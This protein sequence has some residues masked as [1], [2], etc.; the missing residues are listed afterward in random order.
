MFDDQILC[1]S[2]D[3][4]TEHIVIKAG[5]E[6]LVRCE[7]CG[8]VH[9]VQRE[10]ERFV[11]LKVIVSW[12]QHSKPHHIAMPKDEELQVGDE[13]LV[14]DP[15]QDVVMTEITS[16][17]AERRV[18]AAP[19]KDVRTVWARAIDEVPLKISV[20]RSGKTHA[21]KIL[22]P[23][24]EIIV[25]GDTKEAEGFRFRVVKIKLRGEGFADSAPARAITRVW[26]RVL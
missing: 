14:D 11:N 22:L 8:S 13:L 16:L 25:V 3:I 20:Y 7:E 26:G 5:Q 2:C 9:S 15:S 4:E 1:P 19:A 12:D 17:E 24:D 6:N 18:D 23:G 21:F 10:K